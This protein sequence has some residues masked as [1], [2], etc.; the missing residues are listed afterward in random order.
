M[1]ASM[2]H[3]AKRNSEN[4]QLWHLLVISTDNCGTYW[5]SVSKMRAAYFICSSINDK[6]EPSIP[7]YDPT[8][9]WL[10][11]WRSSQYISIIY[12]H[13]LADSTWCV[14]LCYYHQPIK[15]GSC[16]A[17]GSKV[18]HVGCKLSLESSCR[19][20]PVS[21]Y[22]VIIA[23]AAGW[24]GLVW[25]GFNVVEKTTLNSKPEALHQSILLYWSEHCHSGDKL[26]CDKTEPI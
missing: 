17:S 5:S 11:S 1:M 21:T 2:Y 24:E 18:Q 20:S 4:R 3:P 6:W 23:A 12:R 19:A 9:V 26:T 15:R 13:W 14:S 7:L 25:T 16:R 10:H 22:C 8:Y